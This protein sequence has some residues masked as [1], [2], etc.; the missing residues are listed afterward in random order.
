[1]SRRGYKSCKS[2]YFDVRLHLTFLPATT[3][4]G[5]SS[6]FAADFCKQKPLFGAAKKGANISYPTT[7]GSH[8]TIKNDV[9]IRIQSPH[10]GILT[11]KSNKLPLRDSALHPLPIGGR[12]IRAFA[13][14]VIVEPDFGLLTF[15]RIQIGTRR[16]VSR[17]FFPPAMT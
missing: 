7:I 9:F 10:K 14:R 15:V 11:E 13:E 5:S 16:P 12:L 8:I 3:T 4:L 2:E 1:M 6:L 17:P